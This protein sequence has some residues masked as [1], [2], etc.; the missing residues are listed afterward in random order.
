MHVLLL[1]AQR[2]ASLAFFGRKM[3]FA[4]RC[5]FRLP[6]VHDL[7]VILRGRKPHKRAQSRHPHGRKHDLFVILQVGRRVQERV[8]VLLHAIRND[9]LVILQ[10][11]RRKESR[12]VR[13]PPRPLD[14]TSLSFC[15]VAD[16]HRER[17]GINATAASTTS[18]SSCRSSGACSRESPSCFTAASTNSFVIIAVAYNLGYSQPLSLLLSIAWSIA[19][20]TGAYCSD[21]DAAVSGVTHQIKQPHS[22]VA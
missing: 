17:I 14:T 18:L 16:A 3:R 10:V 12:G 21:I 15:Q 7:L 2:R 4:A 8:P 6:A 19:V 11:A 1:S 5:S 13:A 9:L 20:D 22:P